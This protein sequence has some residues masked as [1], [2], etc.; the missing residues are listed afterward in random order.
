MQ[1]KKTEGTQNKYAS[2]CAA[3]GTD[4]TPLEVMINTMK[5]NRPNKMGDFRMIPVDM[6]Y[7]E[8]L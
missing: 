2:H 6:C 7:I 8:V 4:V 1:Q 3:Q 5:D